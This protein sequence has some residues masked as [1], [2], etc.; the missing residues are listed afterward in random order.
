MKNPLEKGVCGIPPFDFAQGKQL[1]TKRA[2]HEAPGRLLLCSLLVCM[3]LWTLKLGMTK[4]S[5]RLVVDGIWLTAERLATDDLFVGGVEGGFAGEGGGLGGDFE[6]VAG[7][8]LGGMAGG[9]G[10]VEVVA[11]DGAAA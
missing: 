1:R 3:K 8:G 10:F 7:D 11:E 2:K 6:D 5:S 9:A 4:R